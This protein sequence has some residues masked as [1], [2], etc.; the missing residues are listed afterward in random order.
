VK[1]E[2]EKQKKQA[3]IQ[4]LEKELAE[5]KGLIDRLSSLQDQELQSLKTRLEQYVQVKQDVRVE[6]AD[7]LKQK[8]LTPT[9]YELLKDSETCSRLV[10]VISSN[11][12]EFQKIP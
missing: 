4:R 11:P 2:T 3:E 8:T 9:T 5:I 6:T 1:D 10:T 12:K 7:L